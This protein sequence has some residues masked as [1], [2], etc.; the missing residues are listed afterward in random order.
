MTADTPSGKDSIET[1][2]KSVDIPIPDIDT[3]ADTGTIGIRDGV[4]YGF[5]LMIYTLGLT[6]IS[7][8]LG[9]LSFTLVSAAGGA[10]NIVVTVILGL[11][12]FTIS[13]ISFGVFVAGCAGLLY[14]IIADAVDAGVRPFEVQ[15]KE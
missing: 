3:I 11:I 6:V 7:T 2:T 13:T 15:V 14:K 1:K 4:S 10:D 12:A 8:V 5:G 9:V